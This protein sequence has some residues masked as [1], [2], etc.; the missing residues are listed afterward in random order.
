M[1]LQWRNQLRQSLEEGCRKARL[2]VWSSSPVPMLLTEPLRI[3]SPR[4]SSAYPRL[5]TT[6]QMENRSSD[7][8]CYILFD[9]P[10]LSASACTKGDNYKMVITAP[11][12]LPCR[13]WSQ[14]VLGPF[15]YRKS[16]VKMHYASV[17]RQFNSA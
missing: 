9:L 8:C 14:S 15:L 12:A 11:L 16:R 13:R 1:H 2:G 6:A 3:T 17:E 10:L 7:R 4:A 5:D